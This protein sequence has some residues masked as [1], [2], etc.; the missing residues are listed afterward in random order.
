MR[1][2][3]FQSV[4]LLL[5]KSSKSDNTTLFTSK[6]HAFKKIDLGIKVLASKYNLSTKSKIT[7]SAELPIS[8][9]LPFCQFL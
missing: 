3:T 5:Y 9:F 2:S 1:S 6:T 7:N 8:D 4:G